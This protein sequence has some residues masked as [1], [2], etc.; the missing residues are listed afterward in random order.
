MNEK[1]AREILRP[2]DT[3]KVFP[4]YEYGQ[5]FTAKGYLEA[6]KKTEILVKALWKMKNKVAGACFI[7]EDKLKC[8]H[9]ITTEALAQWE[10][11]K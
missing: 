3:F 1:E 2:F 4:F 10:K 7:G 6:I 9:C 5:T 8:H 11:D